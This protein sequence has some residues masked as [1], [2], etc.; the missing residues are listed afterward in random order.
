METAMIHVFFHQ[1][2]ANVILQLMICLLVLLLFPI[3]L[4]AFSLIVEPAISRLVLE[5]SY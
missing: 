4:A 3:H 2:L 5:E 1:Q